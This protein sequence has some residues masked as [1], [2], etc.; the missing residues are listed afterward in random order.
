MLEKANEENEIDSK[1]AEADLRA[2]QDLLEKL[3]SMWEGL[4]KPDVML[5]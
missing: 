5:T 2:Q 3:G 4:N 1:Q